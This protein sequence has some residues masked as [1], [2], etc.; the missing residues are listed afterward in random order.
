MKRLPHSAAT[1][2]KVIRRSPIKFNLSAGSCILGALMFLL[3]PL[4]LVL[5][6][7]IAAVIHECFHILALK[8][9]R[10]TI[11]DLQ[12]GIGRIVIR[13]SSLH[14]VQEFF[15]ALAGPAG[16]F[17]CLI[18]A[19][20]FPLLALCGV[21]QGLYNLLPVYPLDGGRALQSMADL[22]CPQYAQKIT[23]C[24]SVLVLILIEMTCL[25]IYIDT[26]ANLFLC[27]G[28]YFLLNILRHRKTP[29]KDGRLWV[30]YT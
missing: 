18:F 10:A 8:M 3:L 5:S 13:T 25:I 26:S 15:C 28:V 27:L 22:L 29:C 30:Q 19:H 16:S 1:S 14:P 9:C 20:I 21:M 12:I 7:I 2:L 23:R 17:L 11:F 4:S 6:V 24:V